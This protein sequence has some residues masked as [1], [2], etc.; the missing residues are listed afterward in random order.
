[1]DRIARRNHFT[2]IYFGEGENGMVPY[3]W[4]EPEAYE[5]SRRVEMS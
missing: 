4:R 5:A 2:R 1:V 3:L